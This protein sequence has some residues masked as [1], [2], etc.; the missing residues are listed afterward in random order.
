M[1]KLTNFL[2]TLVSVF[3]IALGAFGA[4]QVYADE[5]KPTPV[6]G[7]TSEDSNY[8]STY[9]GSVFGSVRANDTTISITGMNG[10]GYRGGFKE[11]YDLTSLNT[12]LNLKTITGSAILVLMFNND[13]SQ[14]W[15]TETGCGLA[16]DIMKRD[17]E[18][19]DYLV[20]LFKGSAGSHNVS[21]DGFTGPQGSWRGDYQGIVVTAE[22]D[23]ITITYTVE[24][25]NVII[26]IN[27]VSVTL[28]KATV[29]E[30]ITN[31][32][33]VYVCS[34]MMGHDG[35]GVTYVYDMSL[36]DAAMRNY[37]SEN[38]TYGKAKAALDEYTES[39]QADLTN[40][41]NVRAAMAKRDAVVLVGIK[42][43]DLPRL[44]PTKTAN[45]ATLQ[46]AMDALHMDDKSP[47]AV[48]TE[49]THRLDKANDIAVE[50]NLFDS[51]LTEVKVGDSVLETTNYSY[52]NGV[53]TI[54][55]KTLENMTAGTYNLT[56]TTHG[57]SCV[58]VVTIYTG[59][60]FTPTIVETSVEHQLGTATN[61]E[62]HIDTK[63][64]DIT[65]VT[66]NET[67]TAEYTY[68]NGVFSLNNVYVEDLEAG[69]YTVTITTTD[70]SVSF[71][72]ILKASANPSER[73]PVMGEYGSD[74]NW[75]SMW[76]SGNFGAVRTGV[77]QMKVITT[78]NFG[79]RAGYRN[80]FDVRHL[81]GSLDLTEL[82]SDAIV[83][84]LLSSNEQ[85]YFS[86]GNN[87]VYLEI[88]KVTD[89]QFFVAFGN[90]GLS[91]NQHAAS[92]SEFTDGTQSSKPG[93]TGITINSETGE[94]NFTMILNEDNSVTI[95]V[96]S[97]SYTIPGAFATLSDPEHTWIS[98]CGMT[99]TQTIQ[100]YTIN[101][102]LDAQ[103]KEYY[104][105]TGTF[106][107]AMSKLQ[108]LLEAI[109]TLKT[110][111]QV[112]DAIELKDSINV[113]GLYS[114][115]YNYIKGDYE[116]AC[117][118][119]D[120]AIVENPEIL[121]SVAASAVQAAIDAA[122]AMKELS[123]ADDVTGLIDTATSKIN[124][125][126][127]NENIT[128]EIIKG[129]EEKL[130]TAVETRNSF[131]KTT[132]TA[133]FNEYID[134]IEQITDVTTLR[135]VLELKSKISYKY[136]DIFDENEWKALVES[137]ATADMK[138]SELVNY[139]GSDWNMGNANVIEKDGKFHVV[140]LGETTVY[141][142]EKLDA[143]DLDIEFENLT[144]SRN[145]GSWLSIGIME[146]P[147]LFINVENETVTENKGILFLI[148]YS[149][150]THVTVEMY[151]ISLM[152][153]GFLNSKV[154]ETLTVDITNGLNFHMGIK[155][156]EAAGVKQNY[157]DVKFND[158][159]IQSLLNPNE[160]KISLGEER[161]G[162]L[163]ISANGSSSSSMTSY[164]IKSINGHKLTDETLAKEHT[165]TPPTSTDSEKEFTMGTT[166]SVSYQVNTYGLDITRV[167]IG[168]ATIDSKN[169]TYAN[170]YLS[171][172]NDFL[173]TLAKGKYKVEIH[174]ED[175]KVE[176]SLNVKEAQTGGTGTTTD[177][178]GCSCSGA[179]I[180]GTVM[181][182]LTIGAASVVLLKKREY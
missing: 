70:G 31:P 17:T 169:F 89:T 8:F 55:G 37:Y 95:T 26:T 176:L 53:L 25:D 178:K 105:E 81:E 158:T 140:N 147:S 84:V 56:I 91:S 152:S 101:Y 99:D 135:T 42:D 106:G 65:K 4:K 173:K 5:E 141:T 182:V 13:G 16:M 34:G 48:T 23:N 39:L 58:V 177:K 109:K 32:E 61:V 123:D 157:I 119:L 154:Q 73:V 142:K 51:E 151:I 79:F 113:K 47:V 155:E 107:V 171:L 40:I 98:L 87:C 82:K 168:G 137:K 62:A 163:N 24:G 133:Q 132:V 76:Q 124:E 88:V 144:V 11:S 112:Y 150:A 162:Y 174:T 145:I 86:E 35:A 108:Q 2:I 143:T 30:R 74:V 71:E 120:R 139:T 72:M 130:A 20:T 43:Y 136:E 90:P 14:C 1:K 93:F 128:E 10:T 131:I 125:L 102:M 45:D 9:Q 167:V 121:S 27:E 161:T 49:V 153:I 122:N 15:Y 67:E 129:L 180:V 60:E 19:H 114:Y 159:S 160:F 96:N 36:S 164:T 179:V 44:Q 22:D 115:D 103:L 57:G 50:V 69:T 156:V 146:K 41:D 181:S 149:D 126:K 68:E 100:K 85:K 12:T 134:S 33:A 77:T 38:G 7:V 148:T 80:T 66:I 21:L 28:D 110:A 94:I 83:M 104:S 111:K 92:Y 127:D 118:I 78:S 29:F 52:D 116:R 3:F 75:Y 117:E 63:G 170:G 138:L 18:G 97:V 46:A 165:P 59:E 54:S 6:A 64:N 172:K 175:G 166:S